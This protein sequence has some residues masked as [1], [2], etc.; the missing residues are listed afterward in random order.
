MNKIITTQEKQTEECLNIRYIFTFD[1]PASK[2]ATFDNENT[3]KETGVC[4]WQNGTPIKKIQE[5]LVRRYNR[6][7]EE[8]N[9]EEVTNPSVELTWDGSKWI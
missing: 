3:I 6:R 7:Q 2:V 1:V 4:S 8:L 5:D 9:K